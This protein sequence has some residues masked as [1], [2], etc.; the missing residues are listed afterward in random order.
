[1]AVWAYMGFYLFSYFNISGLVIMIYQLESL[2]I[3]PVAFALTYVIVA[4]LTRP[5]KGGAYFTMAWLFWILFAVGGFLGP[6]RLAGVTDKA[7]WQLILK[8]WISLVG[9]PFLALR[10]INRERLPMLLK[11]TL[12]ASAIG[13]IFSILQ[14]R[15]SGLFSKILVDPGRGAGFWINPNTCAELLGIGLFF[16]IAAPL[17]SKMLNLSLR[18]LLVLGILATLSR[19]GLV[20]LVAGF[21]AY[22]ITAKRMR[23][24]L[25]VLVVLG[26]VSFAGM[27]LVSML[28]KN[29]GTD[30]TAKRL[31]QFESVLQGKLSEEGKTNDRT[32]LWKFG[33]Q[34]IMKQ[35]LLGRGHRAMDVVVPGAL[36]GS[37]YGP[38]NYYIFVWGNS[39]LFAILAFLGYLFTI[40]RMALKCQDRNIR[41]SLVG[42][43]TM[44]AVTAM[45]D[46]AFLNGQSYGPVFAVMVC[47]AYYNTPDKKRGMMPIPMAAPPR[48]PQGAQ[49][50]M[51]RPRPGGSAPSVG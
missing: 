21:L 47:L 14:I 10:A 17:K 34:A 32:E 9:V 18:G 28:A 19:T 46:H 38:H 1:M 4:P 8:L 44:I 27:M 2:P 39:G 15:F 45:T 35:P 13:A 29:K 26:L 31:K 22:G 37:G 51:P 42:I 12:A 25:Q 43:A 36:P 3:Q 24:V 7:L 48:L 40:F 6:N 20:L 49:G 41:A 16:S 11:A 5:K 33:W 50:P 23:V 30:A